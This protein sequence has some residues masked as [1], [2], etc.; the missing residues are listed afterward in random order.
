MCYNPLT[1]ESE[2]IEAQIYVEI[3][4]LRELNRQKLLRRL[5]KPKP[6]KPILPKRKKLV[7]SWILVVGVVACFLLLA[8]ALGVRKP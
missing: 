5:S 1:M 7:L 3:E 2:E 8:L 6:P 4:K